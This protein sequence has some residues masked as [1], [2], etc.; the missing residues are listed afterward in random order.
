MGGVSFQKELYT[1]MKVSLL[2]LIGLPSEF[3]VTLLSFSFILL[4]TPYFSGNDFGIFRVPE[5]SSSSK[6][7]L[8]YAGPFV[9]FV[10]MALQVPAFQA[11]Y[12]EPTHTVKVQGFPSLNFRKGPITLEEIKALEIK[13]NE[14][15]GYADPNLL[16]TIPNNAQVQVIN[17][18]DEKWAFIRVKKGTKVIEGYV[19]KWF[20]GQQTMIPIITE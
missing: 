6:K 14:Q 2:S 4:L 1:F 9:F 19:F 13:K 15:P 8:K 12:F 11:F 20:N 18:E 17:N 16:F 5:F 3:G 10:V 7:K